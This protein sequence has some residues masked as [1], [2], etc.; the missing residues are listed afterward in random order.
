MTACQPRGPA[1]RHI[2]VRPVGD[3]VV[4]WPLSGRAMDIPEDEHR[5]F[6]FRGWPIPLHL[7]LPVCH[8]QLFSRSFLAAGCAVLGRP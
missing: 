2:M 6:I 8:P 1:I 5:H 4:R 7:L 3:E